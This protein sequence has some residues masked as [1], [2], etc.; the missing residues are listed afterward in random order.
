MLRQEWNTMSVTRE[1]AEFKK[2]TVGN[3]YEHK[4]GRILCQP[5]R[6]YIFMLDRDW[7]IMPIAIEIVQAI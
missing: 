3:N 6:A 5:Q 4:E 2:K 7:V 1:I